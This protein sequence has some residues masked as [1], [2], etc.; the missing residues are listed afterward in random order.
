MM[1]DKKKMLQAILG[2]HEKDGAPIDEPEAIDSIVQELIECIHNH[3]VKGAASALK[4][5]FELCDDEH[6]VEE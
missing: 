3:D 6:N 1:G 5:A 4:A 2:P